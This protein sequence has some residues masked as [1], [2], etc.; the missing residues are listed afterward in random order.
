[1]TNKMKITLNGQSFEVPFDLNVLQ[2]LG[3]RVSP[4]MKKPVQQQVGQFSHREL[5]D[6]FFQKIRQD[7]ETFVSFRMF[8]REERTSR[9]IVALH[10]RVRRLE[11]ICG[12]KGSS[13]ATQEQET[14]EQIDPKFVE[15]LM[16][17]IVSNLGQFNKEVFEQETLKNEKAKE[18]PKAKVEKVVKPKEKAKPK[19]QSTAKPKKS[20]I[21]KK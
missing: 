3:T 20:T 19:K 10:N 4:L 14:S 2:G 15:T 9:A 16:K 1:M 17:N 8:G 7:M 18:K 6:E 11:N 5:E 12:V 13:V 21:N